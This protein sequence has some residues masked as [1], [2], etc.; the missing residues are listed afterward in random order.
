MVCGSKRLQDVGTQYVA[1]AAV[2][3]ITSATSSMPRSPS[4][5]GSQ[6]F[7]TNIYAYKKYNPNNWTVALLPAMSVR[8]LSLSSH[9][10]HS[11]LQCPRK[12]VA[13]VGQAGSKRRPVVEHV[14]LFS[15]CA[16]K[17]L[18]KRV[19]FLPQL[20]DS[21]LFL[22]EVKVLPLNNVPHTGRI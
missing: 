5:G 22:W 11:H 8:W 1:S 20:Q 21:L 13:I 4:N 12:Q 10:T 15:F 3:V 2:A 7:D 18:T 9:A 14:L 17:L 19:D 16:L 6:R